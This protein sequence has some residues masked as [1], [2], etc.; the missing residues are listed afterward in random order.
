MSFGPGQTGLKKQLHLRFN[1]VRRL[2]PRVYF[3]FAIICSVFN[4]GEQFLLSYVL[5][6]VITAEVI[7]WIE[8]LSADCFCLV[9]RI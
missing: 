6:A 1:L 5:P 8:E 9:S 2:I 4:V 3:N 7:G